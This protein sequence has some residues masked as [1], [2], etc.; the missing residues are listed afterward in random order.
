[1]EFVFDEPKSRAN[2]SKHGIDFVEAEALWSDDRLVEIQAR[3][4]DEPRFLV[5]GQIAGVFWSAI[6]TYRS[7]RI[8]LISVRRSRSEEVALYEG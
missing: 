7:G 8:R 6:I 5:V 2:K 1:L 3:T 4:D